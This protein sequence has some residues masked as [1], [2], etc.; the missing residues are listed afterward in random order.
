M[1]IR[2]FISLIRNSLNS[3]RLDDRISAEFIYHVAIS[4][5]KLLIKRDADSRRIFKN[6]SLFKKLDCVELEEVSI[7]ECGISLP[8]KTIMRSKKPLP[9]SYLSNYG[10]I[11]QVFN[12]LRDKDYRETSITSYKN[13][14]NQ[15]YQT[16]STGRYWISDGYLYV[17]GSEVE[18]LIVYGLFTDPSQVSSFNNESCSSL[19][20]SDFPC[21]D[22]LI[23]A[24]IELTLKQISI[25]KSIV[26]D[27]DSNLNNNDKQ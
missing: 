24:V 23:S 14:L 11:I 17:P 10:N 7:A 22:Y 9:E 5:A 8:C 12:V 4:N 20:D 6:T 13:L 16:K 26:P 2:E 15:K 27:E 1:T 3:V 19:L 18:T 25:R 21:P